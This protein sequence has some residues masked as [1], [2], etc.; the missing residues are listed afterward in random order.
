VSISIQRQSYAVEISY[1]GARD[2]QDKLI[3]NPKHHHELPVLDARVE[4][5]AAAVKT[6]RLVA[7]HADKVRAY[8]I[9][10]ERGQ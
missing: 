1:L 10:L 4:E 9:E 7:K 2:L 8:L 3:A 6:M 5:L